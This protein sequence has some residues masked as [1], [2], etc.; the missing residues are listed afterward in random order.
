[1]DATKGTSVSR[2]SAD[3]LFATSLSWWKQAIP[4]TI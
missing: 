3:S 1:M 4:K 2:A